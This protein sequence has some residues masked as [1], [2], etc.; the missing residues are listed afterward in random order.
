MSTRKP[1]RSRLAPVALVATLLAA[2]PAAAAPVLRVQVDQKGD[3]VLLGNT[4]GFD[5]V[6]APFAPSPSPVVGTVV[7]CGD[8]TLVNDSSPDVFWRS[9]S[10]AAGQAQAATTTAVLSIPSGATIT[11]AYLYW[12]ATLPTAGVDGSITLDRPGA[13]GFSTTVNAIQSYQSANNAYQSVADVTAIVQANGPGAY[14]VSGVDAADFVNTANDNIFAGWWM[15]VFYQRAS[16]PLKNL[17]LFDGL[18]VVASGQPQNV[19]L[20]GFLVPASGFTGKLGVVTF[21]GD[22][23]IPG[24]QLFFNGGAALSDAQN[25]ANNFFNATRSNL[26]SAVSNVG[27]LPQLTGGPQSMA[28]MD[29]DVVD[30]TSKLTPLQTGA[31]IQ[32]TSTGDV[33]FLAGFVTSISTFKPDFTT[34]TKTA[35][36]VN[37]GSLIPGDVLQ[38][39]I[40]VTNTGNDTSINTVLSD[41][42]PTG[43]TYVPGSLQ[44]T[45]GVNAGSKTDTLGDDQGDY[46]AATRTV[47]VRL[48]TG[49]NGVSGGTMAIGETTTVS[50][51]VTVDPGVSGNIDNQAT[52]TAAGLL[53]APSTD[54]PTDGNGPAGG[55]PPTTVI[56]DQCVVDSD[57]MAPTP[58]CNTAPTPNKCVEC[59]QNSDCPA[60][61]P[62]CNPASNTCVCVPSGAEVC[63]GADNDCNGTIDDGFNV[64]MACS[65]GL[66]VCNAAGVITCDGTG[67]SACN[68]TP[69]TPT[70]E[71][72]DGLDN[73]CD[74]TADNGNPGGGVACGTGKL[75]ECA[76]GTTACTAGALACN[77][78]KQP[79]AEVCDGLDNNCNGVADEGFNVG[80]AC[81]SGLGA[82]M[83]S[84]NIVCAGGAA[85]CSA[86]PGSPSAEVCGNQIDEDCDGNL[87]NGCLDSDG[88]GLS[89]ALETLIGTDPM[90][91]DSDDDGVLDG[92][93]PNYAEDTD[94]DGLINALDPDSDNDGLFDG[95]EMGKGCMNPATNVGKG[96]CIPD[97]D[98][99]ATTTDPLDADTDDGGV[100]DG[101]ED[102]NHNGVVDGNE[103][104][105]TAGHGG[106]DGVPKDSD[107]DGLPDAVEIA[108]GTDPFDADSD[109]DG[110][111]DGQE[112]NYN[113]DTDG[114]GLINALDPDSDNDG[115][116]DGTELG[117][118]C[119]HPNT[120]VSKGFCTPDADPSTT[121]SA[122]DADTDGGGVMDGVEDTN[123]NGALD[124]GE[125]DP[126]VGHG[127]DDA[128]ILDSDGDGL[129]DAV[130]ILIGTN[131]MDADSDDDGVL[132]GQEPN[133]NEDTDGDGL[134]NAL[135]PDS[136]N[137]G[138]FDGTEMG[139]GCMNPAT[140]ASKH[141]CIADADPTTTTSPLVADTDGGGV[142]DGSEDTNHNGKLD[143]NETDPTAGHG[144]DDIKVMDSDGDGLSDAVEILIGTDPM[145]ADSDDDGV[146]D[147]L[148]P[149]YN[150]DT[151]GDGL[152]NALDP[153]SDNDGL[154]D[155][156]E[157]GLGCSGQG[158]D[159]TKNHCVPDGDDG[160]T[161]T[162]PLVADTDGG[163]VKDGVEDTNHNGVVDPGETDPTLGHGDDDLTVIDT[164]GDG[165]SDAVEILIGTDPMDAD[166]DDD[167]VLD[168][169]EPNFNQDTDGDGL[170]NALDPDSDNDGL[171]DGTEMGLGCGDPAT[172]LT[173]MT[174]VPDGDS[175]A[176]TT[177]PL[178]ADTD[179]GGVP[180]GVEDANHN[181][182][183][184]PGELDPNDPSDDKATPECVADSECG[185]VRSG[186][187]CDT[188]TGLC[189]DGC[190]G[191]NGNGCP[192][193]SLCSSKDDTIGTCAAGCATDA[194]CGTQKSG[195]VCDDAGQ[196]VNGCRAKGG[197]TCEDGDFCTS[198][199]TAIGECVKDD[200]VAAGNGILCA[201][202]PTSD[203]RSGW[204]LGVALAALA[205]LRRRRRSSK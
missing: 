98:M 66:G 58:K 34:S 4:F 150:E 112:P 90:D 47:R 128:T 99:G 129:S 154:F 185:G 133:Y 57:C 18:D 45:A 38:Y 40:V 19:A 110:L 107:G 124:P 198:E 181:G 175:G 152:I 79:S 200:I 140:D 153:D 97:G 32:A 106:D 51:Q 8:P 30:V 135:D 147:G 3:F 28:G 148:E 115:L 73:D 103:T 83:A 177:A 122:L 72:C 7:D 41:A 183:I 70:A 169:D 92:D 74:G 204:L 25:P 178:A 13:S 37:G 161:T 36:D 146:P 46:I 141:V 151:D 180:D 67:G 199:G 111:L 69:G 59:L 35:T 9:D 24:D 44:I 197:N 94:G 118:D 162:H 184:D 2:S 136:D 61:T 166:S 27:D 131:P 186:R 108:I 205:G 42:L 202:E 93:E 56:V 31:P 116:F 86:I 113:E 5:C 117:K 63:D 193:K 187:V 149:N 49:A 201:A 126:T 132:D 89:D 65:V 1:M 194:E 159:L 84:G 191:T 88:D 119:S 120:D 158:T 172:D 168:G 75:G 101:S 167:G 14:R 29:I 125:I 80:A 143:P 192:D 53:G 203:N 17:A 155:G 138:L 11:H 102:V 179:H 20:N 12:G 54:T 123:Q 142:I 43:V 144:A 16:D 114:D 33:Y 78:N 82:C 52:I 164:D 171:F 39:T 6:T 10:P 127:A 85:V 81:T 50:F 134:I 60:L 196:C 170:I 121:T 174:C 96:F 165:L 15:A 176:T 22:N 109:D 160:A 137:D 139:K 23:L 104:D 21:E 64:G 130:E 87:D 95:T 76:A 26:G 157:M 188:M 145:D 190:R 91:A 68:A 77:Q 100:N 55:V 189:T 105:P 163:G 62:T 182:V 156:T 71:I 195:R 48:G 173:K